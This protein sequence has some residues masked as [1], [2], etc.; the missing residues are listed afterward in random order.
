MTNFWRH[1][2]CYFICRPSL[3]D[4]FVEHEIKRLNKLDAKGEDNDNDN[5]DVH[6]NNNNISQKDNEQ[7]YVNW[8]VT[9]THTFIFLKK[10]FRDNKK[11]FIH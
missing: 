11:P 6:N 5:D 4:D 10:T 2:L 9:H 3:F 8:L 1:F 7:A